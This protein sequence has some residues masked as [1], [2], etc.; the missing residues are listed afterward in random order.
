MCPSGPLLMDS[1]QRRS[2]LLFTT[3]L[4]T[5]A[6]LESDRALRLLLA[7]LNPFSIFII[8]KHTFLHLADAVSAI[9]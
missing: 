2:G 8:S 1:L 6:S 5:L 4:S 3:A 7:K 9:Q